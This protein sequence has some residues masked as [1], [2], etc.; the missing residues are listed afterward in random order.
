MLGSAQLAAQSRTVPWTP[1][2]LEKL[3]NYIAKSPSA[4]RALLDAYQKTDT[5]R[6][7]KR[8]RGELPSEGILQE[9]WAFEKM[10]VALMKDNVRIQI[11]FGP[12]HPLSGDDPRP[13]IIFQE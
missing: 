9:E 6:H 7:I 2:A 11:V 12:H 4:R 5:S 13:Y 1:L 3:M 10:K 8:R